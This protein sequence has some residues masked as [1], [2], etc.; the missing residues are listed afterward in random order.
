MKEFI[1]QT[2]ENSK[3]N[4]SFR[5]T[6]KVFIKFIFNEFKRRYKIFNMPKYLY[7]ATYRPL[8]KSIVKNG[9]GNTTRKN[10][11]DSKQGVVYL[12]KD[13]NVAESYAEENENLKN[14]DWLDE[15]IILKIDIN[16]LDKTKLKIDSNVQDNQ[17]DTLE[18]HGTIK[19]FEVLK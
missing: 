15:I 1:K 14:E 7:H 10:W 12:A 8:L 2:Y 13:L 9:L 16:D 6:W 19:N 5:N 18:Y 17:G 3:S 4:Q 11:S